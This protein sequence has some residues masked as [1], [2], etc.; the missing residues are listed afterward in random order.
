M[1]PTTVIE[2]EV[3]ADRSTGLADAVVGFEIHLLV[4]HAVR[5]DQESSQWA[6][7]I[8]DLAPDPCLPEYRATGATDR[9]APDNQSFSDAPS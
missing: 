5:L 8:F 3:S 7:R 2:V 6:D 4:F 1:G 9:P